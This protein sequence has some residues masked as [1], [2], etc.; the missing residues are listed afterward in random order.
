M[1]SYGGSHLSSGC[2][3]GVR[4]PRMTATSI[5][6]CFRAALTSSV[7]WAW[8]E[9]YT[10]SDCS[11]LRVLGKHWRIHSLMPDSSIHPFL[12]KETRREF[13][14][15]RSLGVRTPLKITFGGSL[16]PSA[17][18]AS[19]TETQKWF[20]QSFNSNNY[21]P[22]SLCLVNHSSICWSSSGNF[23][24]KRPMVVRFADIFNSPL[25]SLARSFCQ[26]RTMESLS[27]Y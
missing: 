19:A 25:N 2:K 17:A 13:G 16:V 12:W 7:K 9:S 3:T 8:K 10:N 24:V 5:F 26:R 18:T 23:G 1:F 21:S 11:W 6:R 14:M 22:C 20:K 27:P 4:P 15:R